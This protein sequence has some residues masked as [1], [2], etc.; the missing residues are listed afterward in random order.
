MKLDGDF[1]FAIRKL[2]SKTNRH[3]E[4][5]QNIIIYENLHV[6]PHGNY[7]SHIKKKSENEYSQNDK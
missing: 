1:F 5:T 2:N 7:E 4:P 3:A 6:F